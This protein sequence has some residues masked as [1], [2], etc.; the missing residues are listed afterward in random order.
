MQSAGSSI[1]FYY[2]HTHSSFGINIRYKEEY[3]PFANVRIS[4]APFRKLGC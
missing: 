3:F 4:M 2:L 1:Q